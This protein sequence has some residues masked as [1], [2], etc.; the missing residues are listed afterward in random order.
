MKSHYED[1]A[2]SPRISACRYEVRLL[3]VLLPPTKTKFHELITWYV[4]A[5][6]RLLLV[7]YNDYVFRQPYDLIMDARA[8]TQ[9]ARWRDSRGPISRTLLISERESAAR[10]RIASSIPNAREMPMTV[11]SFPMAS[12]LVA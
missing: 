11:A 8:A 12:T 3:A 9:R 2:P 10:D 5:A 6:L 7:G 4:R 1:A